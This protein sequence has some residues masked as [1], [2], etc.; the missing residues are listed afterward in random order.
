MLPSK[1]NYSVL[2]QHSSESA[3]ILH[4]VRVGPET[5]KPELHQTRDTSRVLQFE[6][7]HI[8]GQNVVDVQ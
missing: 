2:G 8:R 1:G 3:H 5:Y 6:T 4:Q 7:E